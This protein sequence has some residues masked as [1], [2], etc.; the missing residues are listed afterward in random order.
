[1]ITDHFQ[2]RC[3]HGRRGVEPLRIREFVVAY[4]IGL[5]A[6]LSSI[7]LSVTLHAPISSIVYFVIGVLLTRFISRRIER[8]PLQWNWHMASIA[9]IARAKLSTLLGWPIALPVLI[10]QLLLFKFL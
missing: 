1:M 2:L 4:L 8:G 9:D 5:G 7:A 3:Q 10:W 6:W